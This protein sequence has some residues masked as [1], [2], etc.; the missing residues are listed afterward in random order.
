MDW[1]QDVVYYLAPLVTG[2][3]TVSLCPGKSNP[4]AF[5]TKLYVVEDL[6]DPTSFVTVTHCNDDYC[7]YQSQITVR[8]PGTFFAVFHPFM[9]NRK[10]GRKMRK[11]GDGENV[12]EGQMCKTITNAKSASF[13]MLHEISHSFRDLRWFLDFLALPNS[14]HSPNFVTLATSKW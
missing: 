13:L 11:S 12:N 9:R 8:P 4:E 10:K 14:P 5:D 1:V 6:A 7:A 2:Q 3:I